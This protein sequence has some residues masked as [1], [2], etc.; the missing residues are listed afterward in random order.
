M[1]NFSAYK[2]GIVTKKIYIDRWKEVNVF[3]E[4]IN[5]QEFWIVKVV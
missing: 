3:H 2:I 5:E 4:D 1:I